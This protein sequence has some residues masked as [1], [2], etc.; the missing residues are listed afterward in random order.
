[1]AEPGGE[2]RVR[3]PFFE[4]PFDLLLHLV[5]INEMEITDVSLARLTEQYLEHLEK[6][7]EMDLDI[8]GDFLVVAAT[9]LQ[10]KARRLL[11]GD[12]DEDEDDEDEDG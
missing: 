7:K 2:Y 11:P 10:I 5:K 1:M 6:M 12:P 3:L 4:G 9:L 8:A